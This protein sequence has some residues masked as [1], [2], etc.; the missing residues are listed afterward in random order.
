MR[1]EDINFIVIHCSATKADHNIG[2]S[3]IAKWHRARGWKNIG[4]HFVIK[5][6]GHIDLGRP[7]NQEG[8]HTKG[9]NFESWG[10]CLAGGID[11]DGKPENN[12]TKLQFNALRKLLAVLVLM[13]PGAIIT[14]HRDFSPDINNDGIIEEWEW[15][16]SCPCFDVAEWLAD[17]S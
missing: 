13:T 16:K 11:E 3:D 15:M 14:G 8:A 1:Q 5:R 6:S 7:L 10:I 12:F 9:V 2:A 17:E 4:Y